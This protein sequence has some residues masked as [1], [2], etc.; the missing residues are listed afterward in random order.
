MALLGLIWIIPLLPALGFLLNGLLGARVLPKKAVAWIACGAVLLSFLLSLGAILSLPTAGAGAAPG[1]AVD[2][3]A[4][5]ATLT[6]YTWMPMGLS[7]TGEALRVDWAYSLDPLSAVMLLVVSGVGFL[8]H[9]YSIGYMEHEPRAAFAR[10]FAYLN[11]FMAMMLVL[12]L[13]ASL[14]VVFVGWEGVGL[15][16]Y[17]LI[18]FYYDRMFDE[19]TKMTCA[20]AGRKA[21]IV[22]R[23]GDVGFI[24]GMLLLFAATGTLDIQGVLGKVGGLG[25]GVC[26]LAA[27]FLFIGACGKS[28]QIPLYVWLPDAMAG[29]T[30][31]SA[32]IHAAT[33]V[34]A[35]VYVTC[36]MAPLYVQAPAAMTTVAVIGALTA[37]F[38]ASIGLAQTDIKKVLAYST[39][40]QL[41]YMMLA[42]GVGA[43]SASIF[44]LM[45]HAFFKA[46]L[47]L[48]AGSVIHAMSGEQNIK[49]M[50]G[51]RRHLP[52]THATFLIAVL[53][54]A[55][56][57]P[58]AGFFSKDE[59]LAGVLA[60]AGE[61]GSGLL[62]ALWILGVVT[63]GITAFYMA[64]LYLLVF[65]GEPRMNEETKRH[66][67]ESPRVMTLPL[68][69]LA[70]GS[71]F[72]GL[73][74]VPGFLSHGA[75]PNYLENYL[76]P[77]LHLR[78][79]DSSVMPVPS[80]W[81]ALSVAL[82][83]SVAGIACAWAVYGRRPLPARVAAAEPAGLVRVVKDEFYVDE[84]I[85]AVV[86]RP[87]DRLC[88]LA[89][90]ID[91]KVVD[92]LVNATAAT[93]DLFSQM[94]RLLQTGYVR[95]YAL[96]FFLATIL[97]LIYAMR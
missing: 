14:P 78:H 33:M 91:E 13:G 30:P 84:A 40:S 67:H 54:I 92:G 83:V 55:G 34:T 37:L 66:L 53:A 43:F 50:G 74:G 89:S 3:H 45:T 65:A 26:T 73:L 51:L 29:P 52:V 23:I 27:L 56:I 22:N 58:F 1:L 85:E 61:V 32:L 16:S 6:L 71:A 8:I 25:P 12:V 21:F 79:I 47:F 57:P 95:N 39:V 49:M 44:H 88:R 72:A 19:K 20:D 64:R 69:V 7:E 15:C 87:Y 24:L 94:V 28:A 38:A 31:V 17:L 90:A 5:R 70:I 18:G 41:G 48:G 81:T 36:R 62:I 60:A 76:A 9:V 46:L 35:G 97:I 68:V 4:H 63:A 77:L 10:F 80:E 86:V 75:V 93:T 82:L 59:I 96:V 2:P 11:L 42:A